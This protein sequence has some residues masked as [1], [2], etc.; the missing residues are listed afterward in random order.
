VTRERQPLTLID[1]FA[2]GDGCARG[3]EV[4]G[5]AVVDTAVGVVLVFA[6]FSTAVSR[7]NETVANLLRLRFKMLIRG[8]EHMLGSGT[9][10]NVTGLKALITG[11]RVHDTATTTPAVKAVLDSRTVLRSSGE[12][13]SYM[14]GRT[15]ALGLIEAL[16]SDGS[17]DSSL[18]EINAGVAAL[19]ED[20]QK[21]L[22]PLL[23]VS[24]DSREKFIAE[25]EH[26]YDGTMQRVSGLYKRMIQW[27]LLAIACVLVVVA[28]VDT[29]HIADTFYRNPTVR[30]IA[31]QEATTIDQQ[32]C[33]VTPTGATSSTAPAVNS[34]PTST[35]VS[36]SNFASCLVK[37]TQDLQLP[38][39][40][41]KGNRPSAT[42]GW[43]LKVVGWLISL[44]ALS[45]GATFWFDLLGN[46]VNLRNAGGKP[47]EPP[48]PAEVSVTVVAAPAPTPA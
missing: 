3:N 22:Q 31:V 4:T 8:L 41:G 9:T 26:W 30:Q 47:T 37:K 46:L 12:R 7:I 16:E 18:S 15:F 1:P 48:P 25:L 2:E 23:K 39:F 42:G 13:P 40:W 10:L 6:I 11:K 24:E 28:N 21:V 17:V 33:P 45:F 29:I 14:S 5:S 19:P 44:L 35:P 43:S 27:V 20:L 36:A 34:A 38:L 32:L